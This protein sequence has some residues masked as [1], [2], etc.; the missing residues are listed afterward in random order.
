MF[1]FRMRVL[2]SR[3]LRL[4][5]PVCG[6]G[7]LY[8]RWFRMYTECSACHFVYEREPGYFTGGM[9]INLTITCLIIVFSSIPLSIIALNLDI[10]LLQVLIWGL[11]L[12][13]IFPLLFYRHS[14]SIWMSLE[15]L[16]HPVSNERI[17]FPDDYLS[18]P[19]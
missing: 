12:A 7:K 15:H 13:F 4:R 2:L 1:F 16:M 10:P 6:E 19:D 9:A 11:V 17:F 14:N 5:C 3:G 8:R 18:L